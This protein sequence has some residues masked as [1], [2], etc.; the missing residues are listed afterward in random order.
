LFHL[1]GI[2]PD[3]FRELVLHQSSLHGCCHFHS[4]PTFISGLNVFLILA[5]YLQ[6]IGYG[7][8][9]IKHVNHTYPFLGFY[10][11]FS[12]LLVGFAISNFT[13]ARRKRKQIFKFSGILQKKRDLDVLMELDKG[14]GVTE[15]EFILAVLEHIGVIDSM[16]H[17]APW[18]EVFSICKLVYVN[19][20]LTILFSR[21]RNLH[22]LLERTI[23]SE[24]R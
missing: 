24:K 5:F 12:T 11:I 4:K 19:S 15:S 2:N 21:D 14:D 6:T 16:Q 1:R 22:L 18:K 3:G 7:D 9:D 10:L 23:R 13:A 20:N 8:L 17:V